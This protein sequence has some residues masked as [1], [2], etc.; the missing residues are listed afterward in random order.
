MV[1]L[2]S[3][4][5]LGGLR[6]CSRSS[7]S[8]SASRDDLALAVGA[9][10][11]LLL[12]GLEPGEALVLDPDGADHL[13]GELALRVDPAAVGEQ[14]D[15]GQLERLDLGRGV[16]RDLAGDVGEAGVLGDALE[17]A[18]LVGVEDLRQLVRGR[19]R[20]L[21]LVRR[22]EH[23]RRILGDGELLAAAVEDR[24]AR[25]RDHDH[26]P[27]LALCL[28]GE[29]A[30]LDPLDPDRADEHEREEDDEPG[31]QESD[32]ALDQAHGAGTPRP[33]RGAPRSRSSRPPVRPRPDRSP[34]PRSRGRLPRLRDRRSRGISGRDRWRP[35]C[36]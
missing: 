15:A 33:S 9:V 19:V 34:P 21:D 16:E 28:A 13:A 32:P 18:L 12:R 14:A 7:S 26:L 36:P 11:S 23:G 6:P 25:P 10:E 29:A 8:P 5:G 4:P 24:S 31:E 22:R 27:L 2:R 35:R 20:V 3:A 1:S 17:H 30:A